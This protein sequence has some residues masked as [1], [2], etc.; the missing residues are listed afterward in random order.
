MRAVCLF[1]DFCL[2]CC[3]CFPLVVV[4]CA[5]IVFLLLALLPLATLGFQCTSVQ[6]GQLRF[7]SHIA[8]RV[9]QEDPSVNVL[10]TDMR[11]MEVFL[12]ARGDFQSGCCK[13]AFKR[14]TCANILPRCNS[15]RTGALPVCRAWMCNAYFER[16]DT[17]KKIKGLDPSPC[18]GSDPAACAEQ[19][20]TG[21]ETPQDY[22]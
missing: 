14:L 15:T 13:E 21:T 20:A 1:P 7:C 12:S 18:F 10:D 22:D 17:E 4:S 6:A 3:I 19:S 5:G 9:Y 2:G 11:A 8:Y 16:T